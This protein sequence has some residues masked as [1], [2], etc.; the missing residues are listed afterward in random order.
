MKK[1]LSLTLLMAIITIFII[2]IKVD[3]QN[4]R[5]ID[6]KISELD[7]TVEKLMQQ[8][9]IPGA[10]LSIVKDGNIIHK[11]GYGF[12]SIEEKI[13]VD[14]DKT[15]FQLNSLTKIFTGVAIMQLCE[16][17]KLSLDDSIDMYF[18]DIHNKSLHN[19]DITIF[20]LMTHT[21]G[22]DTRFLDQMDFEYKHDLKPL[23]EVLADMPN[24]I[25]TPGSIMSY[26]NWGITALGRIVEKVSGLTIGD[27]IENRIFK[28]LKMD[29]S[30]YSYK[31]EMDKYLAQGYSYSP[32]R[33]EL[34]PRGP[35]RYHIHPAGISF[36]NAGDM[37]KFVQFLLTGN[38]QVLSHKYLRE[39]QKTQFT[40]DTEMLGNGLIFYERQRNGKIVIGHEGDG[41][42]YASQ[43]SLCPEENI[44]FFICI[45]KDDQTSSKFQFRLNFEEKFYELFTEGKKYTPDPEIVSKPYDKNIENYFG[46]YFAVRTPLESPF[47]LIRTLTG[48]L[49]ISSYENNSIRIT[50]RGNEYIYKHI[51]DNKFKDD[52]GGLLLFKTDQDIK[53]VITD[54]TDMLGK[55]SPLSNGTYQK[56]TLYESVLES[57][58]LYIF[59]AAF[60]F[61]ICYIIFYMQCKRK[62]IIDKTKKRG[63][64]VTILNISSMLLIIVLLSLIL[65][66]FTKLNLDIKPLLLGYH[67]TSYVLPV[68]GIALLIQTLKIIKYRSFNAIGMSLQIII[69]LIIL[70]FVAIIINYNGLNIAYLL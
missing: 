68:F 69:T 20:N 15:L 19:Q 56:L 61:S 2:P 51:G 22:F 52:K 36:S 57:L 18:D 34:I 58:T 12:A 66:N 50:L 41:P 24:V 8:Y 28:P 64:W 40:Y 4:S 35:V 27:Y 16:E 60:I 45:N 55:Y 23:K 32:I 5:S 44:G 33:K 70:A 37:G 25:R 39:M 21:A 46:K 26:S 30:Y 14:P 67:I 62:R 65:I 59:A 47:K 43:L 63:F 13:K 31:P 10:S 29:H 49:K 54:Y 3:S 1:G 17:G 48:I 11:K 9:D 6:G 7:S 38:E 42:T 53:Y